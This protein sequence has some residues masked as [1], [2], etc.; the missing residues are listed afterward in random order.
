MS[1]ET[2][3]IIQGAVVSRINFFHTNSIET[4]SK[5]NRT[6]KIYSIHATHQ[7][8]SGVKKGLHP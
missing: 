1:E 7:E 2:T 8:N 5:I 3:L 6:I 4:S